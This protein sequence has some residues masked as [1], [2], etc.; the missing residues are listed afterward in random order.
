MGRP[1]I[2]YCKGKSH[3]E[4]RTYNQGPEF[5]LDRATVRSLPCVQI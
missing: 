3:K 5:E 1:R 2:Q 4:F